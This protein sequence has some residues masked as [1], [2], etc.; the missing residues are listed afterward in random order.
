MDNQNVLPKDHK[1]NGPG[2]EAVA[3]LSISIAFIMVS[4]RFYVRIRLKKLW[5][6]DFFLLLGMLI[7]LAGFGITVE[8]IRSGLGQHEHYLSDE[9]ISL[10]LEMESIAEPLAMISTMFTKISI[11]LFL[12]RIFV[13]NPAWK[14]ALYFIMAVTVATNGPAAITVF[15]QCKPVAKVWDRNI[16]GTC[17]ARETQT[18]IFYCQGGVS[19]FTDFLLAFLPTYFLKDIKISFRTKLSICA[20]MSLGVFT[21]ICAIIRTALLPKLNATDITY[22]LSALNNWAK[23]EENVAIIAA[24]GPA[25][26][27]LWLKRRLWLGHTSQN[28]KTSTPVCRPDDRD[29]L[30]SDYVV[31]DQRIVAD[32]FPSRVETY[33]TAQ[34][35]KDQRDA[36]SAVK[37]LPDYNGIM[38]TSDV[39]MKNFRKFEGKWIPEQSS[40]SDGERSLEEVV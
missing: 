2:Q 27:P 25:L 6:D 31:M 18:K 23:L 32:V 30:N 29:R 1:N 13:T 24:A 26:R 28:Q 16:E 38:K 4:L 39:S 19:I 36:G 22:S 8:K 11:C 3:G 37:P 17:W 35:G 21:G 12:L 15:A 34:G 9:Q 7:S 5:W 20:L 33:I 14:R 40:L 10:A